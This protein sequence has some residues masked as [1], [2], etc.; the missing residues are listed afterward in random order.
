MPRWST[1]KKTWTGDDVEFVKA[2]FSSMTHAQIGAHLDRSEESVKGFCARNGLVVLRPAWNEAEK[3]ILREGHAAGLTAAEIAER[4]PGR[5]KLSVI[6]QRFLIGLSSPK[7]HA[8]GLDALIINLAARAS[9]TASPRPAAAMCW[10]W[11]DR[12]ST[13]N[14]PSTRGGF[15]EAF[16]PGI[17]SRRGAEHAEVRHGNQN[18]QIGRRLDRAFERRKKEGVDH[19]PARQGHVVDPDAHFGPGLRGVRVRLPNFGLIVFSAPPR[20]C[21]RYSPRLWSLNHVQR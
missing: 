12:S 3:K 13:N 17:V 7:K 11:P 9:E 10:T 18:Q 4:I 6:R 15:C 19:H 2:N 8:N 20:L 14:T 21:V 5:T 16:N 1:P